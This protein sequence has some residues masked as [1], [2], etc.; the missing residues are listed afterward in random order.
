M[1]ADVILMMWGFL[2]GLINF[3]LVGGNRDFRFSY[4][5]FILILILLFIKKVYIL[6]YSSNIK[7]KNYT[8]ISL[9]VKQ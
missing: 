3:L 6:L 9:Y 2:F 5:I 7:K 4:C 1:T 8:L